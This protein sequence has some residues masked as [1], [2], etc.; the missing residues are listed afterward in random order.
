[1]PNGF[2]TTS[3]CGGVATCINDD[4]YDFVAR[5]SVKVSQS[6]IAGASEPLR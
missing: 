2:D 5:S 3:D 6:R 1:M 4:G